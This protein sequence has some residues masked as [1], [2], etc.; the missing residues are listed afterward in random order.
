LLKKFGLQVNLQLLTDTDYLSVCGHHQLRVEAATHTQT[1]TST[2]YSALSESGLMSSGNTGVSYGNRD[3]STDTT[4]SATS[5]AGSTVGSVGGNVSLSAGN[6]FTQRGSDVLAIGSSTP[7]AQATAAQDNQPSTGNVTI[8][9]KKVDIVEA[10]E[11]SASA[12]EQKF[13]QTG[14][15]LALESSVLQGAQTVQAMSSPTFNVSLSAGTSSSQSNS[16]SASDTARGSSVGA[17]GNTTITATGDAER[18]NVLVQG[19][20][21][22]AGDTVTLSADN[23][24]QLLAAANT[25]SQTSSQKSS[26]ASAGVSLGS[27]TGVNVS[28]S[29]G[30]GS[31]NGSDLFYTNTQV[32]AGKK[33]VIKSGGDTTLA[34]ATVVAPTIQADVGGNLNIRSLSDTSRFNE[35]SQNAGGSVTIGPKPG[36]SISL[37]GSNISSDYQN[38]A[39]QSALRAGDGGFN[40]N[41]TGNTDLKGGAITST[42]KAVNEAKNTFTTAKLTTSDI[43]NSASFSAESYA[44]TVGSKGG[45][46]GMGQEQF[47]EVLSNSGCVA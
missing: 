11:T 35:S 29:M 1:Q 2:R 13:R 20:T 32:D 12:T 7:A 9:A 41:V 31:G 3:Q 8:S 46:A 39:Q 36:G 38:V 30:R 4:F 5:A 23:Q 6:T 44:V 18:S 17:A 21:V 22:S 47:I 14:I 25:A 26:S 34:G 33:A 24:V 16:T 19:S 10:R 43:A 37:A 15:T 42:D 40:V 28:G 45:S 27:D